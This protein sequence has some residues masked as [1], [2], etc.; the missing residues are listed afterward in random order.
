MMGLQRAVRLTAA[1]LL[2]AVLGFGASSPTSARTLPPLVAPSSTG[3]PWSDAE[4]AALK[5]QLDGLF[6]KSAGIRGAHVGLYA[7]TTRD[8][9]LLYSRQSDDEFMPASTLKLL[10][11]SASLA[12]LG[13]GFRFHTE[14]FVT[15][16]LANGTQ[17]GSL[18]V[19]GGGDPFLRI[20]D[21]EALASAVHAAGIN[22]V[23]GDVAVDASYFDR[24]PYPPGWVWDD[25]PFYYAVKVSAA[26]FQENVVHVV[27]NGGA[28]PG[29]PP[30]LSTEFPQT[31]LSQA[32]PPSTACE[33][34]G[35]LLIVPGVLSI[36]PQATTGSG[37]S[38]STVDAARTREGCV[39]IVGSIPAGGS[40][41]VDAAVPSPEA[42]LR[43]AT[44]LVLRKHNLYEQ[45]AA[46]NGGPPQGGGENYIGVG[47]EPKQTVWTHDSE[48]L[49][50]LVADMWFPSDNLLAEL[51]LKSLGVARS[52]APGTTENGAKFEREWLHSI[53]V[54]THTVTLADGSGLSIYDRITPRDLVAILQADWN[55]PNRHIVL[56][57]LPVAGVRGTLRE[58][59]VDTPA[60]G[61]AFVKTGSMTH[62]RGL[63]GFLQTRRHGSVTFALMVDDWNGDSDR[64]NDFRG[65][66][67]SALLGS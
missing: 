5:V 65:S 33:Q 63:A 29:D 21:L 13:T 64:L 48:P 55:G 37:G 34:N 9:S 32:D 35:A 19:R 17:S 42:Y 36:L 31:L 15:G 30:T 53:G 28:R 8:G 38:D 40:D 46:E 7:L 57:A 49:P 3:A 45:Q 2:S 20:A 16:T 24:Q 44:I 41:T 22:A 6:A 61:R 50:K 10:V 52:G 14:A 39:A 25:F 1:A 47:G 58:E 60:A 4:R 51:L 59:F 11:G 27:V 43:G 67:L 18:V 62:V 23:A 26:S 54:D 12:R 66:V 56:D